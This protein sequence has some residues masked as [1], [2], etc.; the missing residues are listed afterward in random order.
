MRLPFNIQPKRTQ[1]QMN[2]IST[3]KRIYESDTEKYKD[4][5]FC[6]Y[7]G[8]PLVKSGKQRRLQTLYEHVTNPNGTPSLK[9]EYICGAENYAEKQYLMNDDADSR[10]G[11]EFGILHS[12]IGDYEPGSSYSNEYINKLYEISSESIVNKRVIEQYLHEDR[13]HEFENALNTD[14]CAYS[15]SIYRKG[16]PYLIRFPSWL[17][18]NIIQLFIELSYTANSFGEVTETYANIGFF[19]KLDDN[20]DF[21]VYGQWLWKTW[22]LLDSHTKNELRSADKIPIEEHK[23]KALAYAMNINYNDGLVYRLHQWY[24]YLIHPRYAK[25]LKKYDMYKKPIYKIY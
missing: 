18:L 22:R 25:L 12:W 11:C 17:T 14:A 8:H 15:V 24:E 16:L 1:L 10:I 21:I 23:A 13:T 20:N 7:C 4:T 6:P 2:A 3:A 9:D 5:M 19:K